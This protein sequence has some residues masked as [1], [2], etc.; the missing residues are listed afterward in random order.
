MLGLK[1]LKLSL[2]LGGAIIEVADSGTNPPYILKHPVLAIV[3]GSNILNPKGL[4]ISNK[5][6]RNSITFYV[7]V[8][9][10]ILRVKYFKAT[11]KIHT[12]GITTEDLSQ[13]HFIVS[14]VADCFIGPCIIKDIYPI[15]GRY[16]TALVAGES[17]KYIDLKAISRNA[18]MPS[19]AISRSVQSDWSPMDDTYLPHG[20]ISITPLNNFRIQYD[21]ERHSALIL[22]QI[23]TKKAVY[24][25]N[26][27]VI[28][29][30]AKNKIE[31][32]DLINSVRDLIIANTY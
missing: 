22:R 27:G 26:S 19:G 11:N 28:K 6:F 4:K 29:C 18:T 25:F 21:A 3:D 20:A 12:A 17:K 23:N 2:L 32:Q 31:A 14:A 1:E 30:I 9:T 5:L 10:R 13:L 15:S 8:Q 7:Q 16:S 24:I